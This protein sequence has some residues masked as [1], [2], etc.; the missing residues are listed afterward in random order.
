MATCI[1]PLNC[2]SNG[3]C[4][5][6]LTS[7]NNLLT[8]RL[9]SEMSNSR[10]PVFSHFG[11][12]I[13]GITSIRAYGAQNA[14]KQESLMRIDRYTRAARTFYNINRSI[15]FYRAIPEYTQIFFF[16]RWIGFRMDIL[17]S[18]FTT[19]L[20]AYLVYGSP[21]VDASNVG[22][23]LSMATLLSPLILAWVK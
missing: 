11:G 14:F 23:S 16:P 4:Y 1:S 5:E 17:G 10:S 19:G 21:V 7:Q 8:L 2:P 13:V 6:Q 22:F 12:A 20:A 3:E 15:T 18:L 9:H